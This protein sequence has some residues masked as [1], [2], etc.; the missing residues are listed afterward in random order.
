MKVISMENHASSANTIQRRIYSFE[1][2]EQNERFANTIGRGY[3]THWH[4]P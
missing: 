1:Q 2:I 4:E 3:G